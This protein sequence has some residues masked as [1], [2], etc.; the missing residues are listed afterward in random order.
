MDVEYDEDFILE[1]MRFMT[2]KLRKLKNPIKFD[3]ILKKIC[4]E[5][6]KKHNLDLPL[7][8]IAKREIS[9]NYKK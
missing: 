1:V 2:K 3:G 9:I 6:K 4:L 7:R 8:K 5:F